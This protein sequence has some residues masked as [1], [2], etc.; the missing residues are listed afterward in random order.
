MVDTKNSPFNRFKAVR[1]EL[2]YTQ[3]EFAK[4]LNIPSSTADI[5]RG[6]TKIPGHALA[7]LMKSFG[8]NPLWI[9]NESPDKYLSQ[10]IDISPK[11]ITIDPTGVENILLVNQKAQ[12]GYS[13]NIQDPGYYEQLPAFSLPLPEFRNATY[14]GFQVAGD[15]MEPNLQAGDW[16]I[17]R[18]VSQT[19]EILNGRVYVVVLRDS[20]VV[21]KVQRTQENTLQMISFNEFYAPFTVPLG[22]VQELWQVISKITFGIE[23]SNSLLFRQLQQS[24]EDLKSQ[25]KKFKN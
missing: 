23:D 9:F 24:M 10:T 3:S 8:I 4:L 1:K 5:E 17:G 11:I 2:R 6:K 18:A 16:V 13:G 25:F 22:D 7:I 12:A 20:V 21:K 15:S 19:Q 14:R